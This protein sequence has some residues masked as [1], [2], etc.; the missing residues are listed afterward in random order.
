MIRID[1]KL[2]K[3]IV[4]KNFGF[5]EYVEYLLKPKFSGELAYYV[6]R[7]AELYP[8]LNQFIKII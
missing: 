7:L 6:H 5:E 3:S 1:Q 2:K 8:E 4:T